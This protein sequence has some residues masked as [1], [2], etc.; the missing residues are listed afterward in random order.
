M[1]NKKPV[2]N[3]VFM[4]YVKLDRPELRVKAKRDPKLPL[5]NTE[6]VFEALMP[7]ED[8]KALQKTY[9]K[10]GVKGLSSNNIK[11]FTA[12]EFKKTFKVDA[13]H[14]AIYADED[15]EYSM[16]KARCPASYMDGKPTAHR[17]EV[18]GFDGVDKAGKKVGRSIKMGNGTLS[19][20]QLKER[21]S[22]FEGDTSIVLDLW[23]VQIVDLVVYTADELGFEGVGERE[24][25]ADPDFEA[26]EKDGF[27]EGDQASS[28]STEV[29][30]SGEDNWEED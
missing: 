13:P 23:A 8:L 25:V 28:D 4:Y 12:D 1:G 19:N 18:V 24:S 29:E 21:I 3:N 30:D 27:D 20:M 10:S 7:Y 2:I 15:G 11:S 26:E 22:K 14:A 16:M 9:K 6:Y 5:L 17:P